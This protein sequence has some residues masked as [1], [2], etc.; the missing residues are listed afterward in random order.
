MA[1]ETKTDLS[2]DSIK[3]LQDLIQVNIDSKDGFNESAEEIKDDRIAALFRQIGQVRAKN[4]DELQGLVA[5]NNEEPVERGSIA[6]AV[7]RGWIDLRSK[8]TGGDNAHVLAEAARGEEH[9]VEQYEE[10][11]KGDPGSAISDVLHRQLAEVKAHSDQIHDLHK[12][13]A[14]A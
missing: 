10:S 1:L 6:A 4:A 5:L 13:Y 9:I 8:V 2:A 7:H 3:H 11:L 12:A 14:A